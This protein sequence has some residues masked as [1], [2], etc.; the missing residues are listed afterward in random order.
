MVVPTLS[1]VSKTLLTRIGGNADIPQTAGL[2]TQPFKKTFFSVSGSKVQCES[3]IHLH[4]RNHV[5]ACS[6]CMFYVRACSYTCTHIKHIF[7]K[8]CEF[9][10][11]K[12][13]VWHSCNDVGHA[14]KLTL[15]IA[16]L[17]LGL[18]TTFGGSAIPM[19]SRPRR[20]TQPGRPSEGKCNEHRRWFRPPPGK[21]R[22]VLCSSELV[23]RAAGILACGM[24][25]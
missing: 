16:R 17:V 20:P 25:A 24:P 10:I 3:L 9:G 18:V 19:L 13:L 21:K 2:V 8:H 1:S 14:N 22:R 11:T 15:H 4:S 5:R 6:M 23:T 12:V 7:A